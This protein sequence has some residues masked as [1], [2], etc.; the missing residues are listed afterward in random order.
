MAD[1]SSTNHFSYEKE[2]RFYLGYKGM[3]NL[4]K[5]KRMLLKGEGNTRFFRPSFSQL[6]DIYVLQNVS[7]FFSFIKTT[8]PQHRDTSLSILGCLSGFTM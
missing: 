5:Y 3:R 8:P 1:S 2:H 6:W 4:I 7:N